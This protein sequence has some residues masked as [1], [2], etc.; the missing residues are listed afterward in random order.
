VRSIGILVALPDEGRTLIRRRLSFES[1]T[2]LPGG[3]WLA[4]SGAGSEAAERHAQSLADQGVEGLVSWGCA[5]A[6]H[7]TLS[8]GTLLLPERVRSVEGFDHVVDAPWRDQVQRVLETQ[9]RPRTEILI[10]S[11]VVVASATDKRA[12]H[13][14]SGAYA[15]DM[16][17]AAVARVA[18]SRSLP[19]LVI[20]SVADPVGL[21]FPPALLNALNPRGDVRMGALLAGLLQKPRAIPGLMTLGS[22]F[23]AAMK[24]LHSA[25]SLLGDDFQYPKNRSTPP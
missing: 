9:H 10:E 5:A 6:L 24:T 22:H 18:A 2:S 15:V 11:S 7:D 1:L 16:E 8:P 14:A 21:D 23:S 3:H 4:V 19:F 12:L 20:R 25:R 17:S 13:Q